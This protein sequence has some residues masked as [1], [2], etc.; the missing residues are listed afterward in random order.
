MEKSVWKIHHG[1]R[2]S[3]A[4]IVAPLSTGPPASVEKRGPTAP[5]NSA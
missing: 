3:I 2:T 4:T 1:A 5:Q